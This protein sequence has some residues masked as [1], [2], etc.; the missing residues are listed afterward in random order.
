MGKEREG[1]EERG[2]K[3]G[4]EGEDAQRGKQLGSEHRCVRARQEEK[5]EKHAKREVKR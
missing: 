2:R 5:D 4:R 3:G 1:G